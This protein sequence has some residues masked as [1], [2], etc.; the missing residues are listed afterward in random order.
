[1]HEPLVSQSEWTY[2]INCIFRNTMLRRLSQDYFES[3]VLGRQRSGKMQ[4]AGRLVCGHSPE[5][6]MEKLSPLLSEQARADMRTIY[7]HWCRLTAQ[8]FM[9]NDCFQDH[10][11]GSLSAKEQ[12]RMQLE[13]RQLIFRQIHDMV[14]GSI[15]YVP[16]AA[17]WRRSRPGLRSKEGPFGAFVAARCRC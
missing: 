13:G 16:C 14:Q 10:R 2:F 3:G 1:M 5:A 17:K 4:H 6:V 15:L 7:V 8:K 9:P 12:L 11:W